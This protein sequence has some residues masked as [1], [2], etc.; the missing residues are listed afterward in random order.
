MKIG[1]SSLRRTQNFRKRVKRWARRRNPDANAVLFQQEKYVRELPEDTEIGSLVVS[2]KASHASNQPLYYSMVAPQD[3]RSQ[4]IFTLDTMN[5]EIRLAKSLDREVLDKHILKVTAYERVDPTISAS[6]TVV[7]HVQDV[8]DN[9]PIFEKDSYF[10]EIREDAPIGTTVLS[11]FARDL[12]D[13][14]N[15]EVEYSLGDGNGKNLLSINSKSGVIQTS[16]PLDRET[17]SLIRLDVIA[18]DK[19]IPKRDSKA[20]VEIT[21]ID[22]NDNAPVFESD[23]YNVTILENATLPMVI[24]T[25]VA[26]D[27]DSGINGKVHY[28]M[29]IPSS[30]GLTIDYSTGEVTL[31]DRIDAKYSPITAVIR[32]KDGAQPALSS[33]VPLTINIVDVNDHAPTLIAAQKLITLEENVAIGEEVGRISAIDEDSGPNGIIKYILKGSEDFVIDEDNGVIRTTKLLDRET[34]AKYD[35]MVSAHDL[36]TPPLNTTTTITIILKDVNDN[37]PL[38]EKS[39]Y[40]V[41][42]SE[43]LPRGSQILKLKATDKDEDQKI[44]YRI[45]EADRDVFSILEIGD[46][47]AILS[48]SGELNPQDHKVR[49]ELSATD[50]GGLQGRTTVNVFIDDVNSAPYFTDH[51]FSVKIP[52]HSPIGYPVIT[53]KAEDDDRG[54]NSKVTYS[55]DSSLFQINPTSGELTVAADLDREDRAT[56]VIGVTASDHATPPLNVTSQ[57]EVI[58]DDVNDNPPQFTSSSYAA[59]ISEDIPVGTSFMQVSAIDADIGNNGIVDYFLNES[60][61]S[62][63]IHLFRLDRTSGTLRVNSKLDRE[64]FPVIVLPIFARDRGNPPLASAS[65]ITLTLTDINDNAP[66]FEQASYDLYI[67]ENSP[68]GSTVGT[69]VARDPDEGENADISF[70]IFGGSDAKLF[71]IEEDSEQNGVVRLLSR[72]EF[73]YEAKTNKFFL[74]LQASSG[75]LSSTVPVRI[76]VSDVNDNKPVLKDFIILINRYENIPIPRQIGFIPAYDPDQNATLEYFLEENDLIEIDKYTG[77][78]LVKQEWKRNI[79]L[80]FKSCVTDGANTECATCRF[81]HV[82]IDTEWLFESFTLALGRM[83]IDDFWDPQVF[84]RFRDAISTLGNW[85]ASD[86]NVISAKQYASD[87]VHVSIAITEH[88]KVVRGW[89][90]VELVKES[91]KKLEQMTLLQMKVIDDESCANEPCSYM[92]KCRQTQKFVGDLTSHETDNFIARTLNTV[93][94]FVCECPPGFTSSDSSGKCDTRLDECYRG[95]CANNSTCVSYENKYRCEC[96]PGWIGRHCEISIHALTCVPGYCES[97]SV[98]EL[99]NNEMRCRHCKFNKDDTDERCRLRSISF[100]GDGLLNTNVDIP[101]TQWTIKFRVATIAHNG[102]LLFTGDKK[103]DFVELSL[104]DRVFKIEFSLGGEKAEAKLEND[105]ENRVNDGEWH[106]VVMEYSNH[107][108]IISMDDCETYPSL[109]LN[110]SPNCAARAKINLDRK[111]QDPTVPC[112]RFLDVSNGIFL[113]GRPG[114]TKH[115]ERAFSGCIS[116]LTLDAE[117]IYFSNIR[118]MHRIGQVHEG[119]NPKRDYCKHSITCPM[120]SKCANRWGGKVCS[121][122]HATHSKVDC[123]ANGVTQNEMRGLSLFEDESF[124]L[125]QPSG[126]QVPFEVEFE[127]RTS[128]TDMQVIAMEFTQR[129]IHYNL[130]I[131]DGIMQFSIGDS[132]TDILTPHISSK[133]FIHVLI[134]FDVESIATTIDGIYSAERKTM[135]AD[136]TLENIYFGIAPG[137]GHPFR[138]EGCLRNVKV[139]SKPIAHKKKGKTRSGCVVPNRCTVDSVCPIDSSCHRLWNKHKCKCHK[140]FI[141]DTCLSICSVKNVCGSPAATCVPSNSTTGYECVCPYG[142]TGKNCQFKAPRQMCPRGWWGTFPKCKRCSCSSSKGYEPQ[143]DHNTGACLCKKSHYSTINGCVKCECGIG[144]N[145]TECD[146]EGYCQCEGDAVG[147]RCDRCSRFDHLLDPKTLKCRQIPGKCP[148]EIEYSIQ[149]PTSLKG[150]IIRQSCPAGESGLATRKCQENGR[151]SDVNSWNCT[152]PE[153]SIMVNKFDIL[154]SSKL[155]DMVS[156]ATTNEA[157]LR[158]RNQQIAAEAI[159][160]IVDIEN[161]LPVKSKSHVRDTRFTDELVEDLG[162][163]MAEHPIEDY[164]TMIEKLW[165][166]SN[167]IAKIHENIPFLPPFFIANDHIVFSFDKLDFGN[168][169]PK[170]NNF[171]NSVPTGFPMLKIMVTGTTQLVYSI[172]P[173]PRCKRCENPMAVVIAN[174]TDPL[175]IEFSIDE[176]DEWKYPECVKFDLKSGHWSTRGSSLIGLNLTH[177]TCEFIGSGI[178]SMFVNDQNETIVRIANMDRTLPSVLA[179][180]AILL[181]LSS[182]IMTLCRRKMRNQTVR[183]GFIFFFTLNLLNLFFIHKTAINQAFCPVRNAILSFSTCAPFAWL[184]LYSLHIYKMLADGSVSPNLTTSLLIGMVFPSL[185]AFTTFLFT[186]QC[187]LSP[188]LWLFWFIV[189]SM[190]LFLLLSFYA[191]T[192]TVLVSLHKKYDVFVA[193]HNVKRAVLQHFVLTVFTLAATMIG[194]FSNYLPVESELLETGQSVA[195][196]IGAIVIFLWS[197]CDIGMNNSNVNDN[198]WL[199]TQKSVLVE[200]TS[201]DPQCA[202]PL[203]PRQ[204]TEWIPDVIPNENA[205]ISPSQCLIANREV[206]SHILSPADKILNDGVGHIYG[207]NMGSLPRFR[208]SQDEADDAYYTYSASRR[209]KPTTF[210]RD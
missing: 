86:V 58:L 89:H 110:I 173:Y 29:A 112:Y 3:S 189:L 96:Q 107:E 50:Q 81:I 91:I 60:S 59:S 139:N 65:E 72:I 141:G 175:L 10:G 12:D 129:S 156:N 20:L 170:F 11:V 42:I 36:G 33:T 19:G 67:A 128:R 82:L 130:E 51:P 92:A 137:T 32:A 46:Q 183:V 95:L 44:S 74:E 154:D 23:S 45:E 174:T 144:A 105:I 196:L 204:D 201:A 202:S 38:F 126:I 106:T 62:A 16:A 78:I 41:T 146:A 25:V 132:T 135:I 6:A 79:D 121:C 172:V 71:D 167:N 70:R 24:A 134:K 55:I 171:V 185:I 152:R 184:F 120:T 163:V 182:I 122:P 124:V 187:S 83:T 28:S 150:S 155:L 123:M 100:D 191:A 102:V 76:H 22:V 27:Q 198:L 13:G 21:V 169:I 53:F 113:G 80:R 207:N 77:K 85:R 39:E 157:T 101:R 49:L 73:D 164:G 160:R 131:D 199:E 2:V 7:V 190:G 194:L 119:C 30:H 178:F 37:A 203:L 136:G 57:I 181:C 43:E 84:Q 186:D 116:D 140:G 54:E 177:A 192:T 200:S 145:S 208:S 188:N 9:S 108:I 147:R 103:S 161:E 159:S 68:V 63:A 205:T 90:A 142:S 149:W 66:S 166:Y 5:G 94:T 143:C 15:G 40:N 127:F 162:K 88:G 114:S 109:Q 14:N 87:V 104:S 8:Q 35:L 193:K 52:E 26:H 206:L 168:I 180:T 56:Y 138:F 195:F 148:S 115:V 97:D 93:N 111:C 98:C 153:Y 158:G 69:I 179:G 1:H 210:N 64:Q 117:P 125:Y 151:W 99:E 47:G 133:H 176:D 31:R 118:E 75:Q 197:I 48:I 34:V 165:I 209:Y 4:N 61:A 18:S 17:L